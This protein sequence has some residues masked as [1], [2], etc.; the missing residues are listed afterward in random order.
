M[1]ALYDINGNPLRTV[2]PVGSPY[3]ILAVTVQDQM[4]VPVTLSPSLVVW[5]GI[6]P[7]DPA[8]PVAG[9]WYANSTDGEAYRYD[10]TSWIQLS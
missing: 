6:L 4:G 3:S 5:R 1:G 7:S 9:D 8:T 2:K 10:G